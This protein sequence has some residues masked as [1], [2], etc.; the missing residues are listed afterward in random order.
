LVPRNGRSTVIIGEEQKRTSKKRVGQRGKQGTSNLGREG[1]L[2][3]RKM[4]NLSERKEENG[5]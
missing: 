1:K 3:S 5:R 2:E 4:R